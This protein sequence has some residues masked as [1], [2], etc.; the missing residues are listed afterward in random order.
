MSTD[1]NAPP[2]LP[3]KVTRGTLLR[4]LGW[5]GLVNGVLF[6][7]VGLRYLF[8]YVWPDDT[9][10]LLYVALTTV[11][12][13]AI[14]A[15]LPLWLLLLPLVLLWPQRKLLSGIAIVLAAIGLT[16]V[17]VDTTI[18]D[19]YRYHMSALTIAIFE[20]STW[21]LAAVTL[22]SVLGFQV[23]LAGIVWRKVLAP[24]KGRP[25]ILIAIA[26]FVCW[27]ASQS[28]HIWADAT[29]YVPVTQF[30]RVLPLY[31]PMKAKRRLVSLGLMDEAEMERR[32]VENQARIPESGQLNYPL[33][34]LNCDADGP[35][36]NMLFIVVDAMRRDQL[37]EQLTP[38]VMNFS[39]DALDFQNHYSGGNSSRM[40][41]FSIFYGLPSTYW[42]SFYNSQKQPVL[43]EQ[44]LAS[45]YQLFLSSAVGFGS[46]SQIDRTVFAGVDGKLAAVPGKGYVETNQAVTREWTD[47]IA[48]DRDN[49]PFFGFLYFDPGSDWPAADG[50]VDSGLNKAQAKEA[51]YQ[52]GLQFIDNEIDT[53]LSALSRS[54]RADN[55]LVVLLSDHGYEFDENGLGY[56]G[57]ASNFSPWQLK[58]V[59]MMRWPGRNPE[60]FT[61]RSA[62]QDIP[63]TLLSEVF[64][65]DN[66]V[67]DYSSG[68]TLFDRSDWEWII[69]GSYN[70]HAIVQPDKYV[71]TYPGGLIEVLGEDYRPR[72]GLSLDGDVTQDVML[73][74]RRF[75]R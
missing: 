1:S 50:T 38:A 46:P 23:M 56:I 36:P 24:K 59:M 19:Q 45:D 4:W 21:V 43:M 28:I 55:T 27:L 8:A 73:E 10:A 47:W 18:F 41:F 44:V 49:R 65:C 20:T 40:G 39:R 72:K 61:H 22:L 66:P 31:Y 16:L 3:A 6:A 14:L 57:H 52:R 37:S 25:G 15:T 48:S 69:A 54:G 30:T 32:R 26:L 9:L 67:S 11:S 29:S 35:L 2:P 70:S 17:V 5:F 75:Y 51:G 7:V 34:P 68:A 63:G 53:V 58:S 74:M 13:F 60:V 64:R 12:H 42:Q 71:V 62:H 33:A